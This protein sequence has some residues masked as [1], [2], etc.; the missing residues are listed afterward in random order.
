[1]IFSSVCAEAS[2]IAKDSLSYSNYIKGLLFDGLGEYEQAKEAYQ[3]AVSSDFHARDIH[4]RLAL[5]YIRTVDFKRAENEFKYLLKLKPFDERARFLLAFVYSYSGKYQVAQDEYHKLLEKPLLELDSTDVRYSLAQLYLLQKDY[6]KAEAE[7]RKIIES[8]PSDSNAYFYLG[9]VNSENSKIDT[10]ISEFSKA[11]EIDPGNSLA[12]NSLSYLYAERGENLDYAL[13]LI[14]KAL[15]F[16]PA[17]GA[18]LDTLGWIYFKKGDL[19]KAI[20]YLENASVM[21]A[22]PEIFEHLGDVYL[23]VGRVE[24]ARK[25]WKKSLE[26]DS[27][28]K[29]IKDKIKNL[30]DK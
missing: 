5:D 27:A 20:K 15:E 6:N 3:R 19:E 18:Y 12:L 2:N 10:A 25:N 14:E 30:K 24:Q 26:I 1:M 23:K 4:Y 28:R 17:N 9:Y 8:S 22:D 21:S 29:H 11:I 16:D 7:Y 13:S